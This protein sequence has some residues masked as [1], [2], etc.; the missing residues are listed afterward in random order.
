[1]EWYQADGAIRLLITSSWCPVVIN[2]AG[3]ALCFSQQDA[4]QVAE[5]ALN[6]WIIQRAIH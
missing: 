5:P 1:M 3:A 4:Q 2:T 6:D